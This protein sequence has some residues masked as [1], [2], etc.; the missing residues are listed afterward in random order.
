VSIYIDSGLFFLGSFILLKTVNKNIHNA[1]DRLNTNKAL[2]IF[3][4]FYRDRKE[5]Y[6]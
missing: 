3:V 2:K 5:L 4:N 6:I 1:L